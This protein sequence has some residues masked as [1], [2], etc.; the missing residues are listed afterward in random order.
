PIEYRHGLWQQHE[1]SKNT[2]SEGEEYNKWLKA[3]LRNAP[4]VILVGEVRD[5]GVA[6][7]LLDAANTGHLAFSTLHTNNAA[8]A[9]ARLKALSVDMN[10]LASVLLGILAQRLV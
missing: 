6:Q 3:L 1:L 10:T 7:I 9:L 4:D 8:M 2:E 5:K